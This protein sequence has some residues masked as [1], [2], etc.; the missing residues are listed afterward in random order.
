M[1]DDGYVP[2]H[3][4]E[5][6]D[7][8]STVGG[9][10]A[11]PYG[12]DPLLIEANLLTIPMEGHVLRRHLAEG[13]WS[14]VQDGLTFDAGRIFHQSISFGTSFSVALAA[15]DDAFRG[16]VNSVGSAM[17]LS[18]NLTVAPANAGLAGFVLASLY[19][20]KSTGFDLQAGAWKDPIM[21]MVQWL[22]QRGDSVAYAPYIL[23]HRPSDR[24]MPVLSTGDSW[25]ETL[26][27]PAQITFNAAVGFPVHT[28]GADY[29]IDPSVPGAETVEATA[30]PADALT[31]NV[32]FGD[33]THTAALTYYAHSCHTELTSAV[34]TISYDVPQAPATELEEKIT[35]FSPICA[36]Q[37]QIRAFNDSLLGD[38]G[39][40][41]IIAPGGTCAELFAD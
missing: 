29:T 5:N 26:Y 7:A 12:G 35:T 41:E 36:F 19:G 30:F 14:Q 39:A 15:T 3:I 11:L 32:T 28:A 10:F 16:I 2:D 20:L 17:I 37:H 8:T 1:G 22:S 6:G 27:T 9:L 25:D 23:R 31:G 4:G 33:R 24:A 38:D 21:G 13:D 40:G 34:C 18:A